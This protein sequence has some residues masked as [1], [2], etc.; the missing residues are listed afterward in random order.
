MS[1]DSIRGYVQIASGIGEATRARAVDI[2]SELV[3]VMSRANPTEMASYVTA[4]ADEAI[5]SAKANREMLIDLIRSEVSDLIDSSATVAKVTDLDGVKAALRQLADDLEGV[6]SQIGSESPARLVTNSAAAV[7]TAASSVRGKAKAA[8]RAAASDSRMTE[9]RPK[10]KRV[11]SRPRG[12]ALTAPATSSEATPT[13]KRVT[14][15]A[16]ETAPQPATVRKLTVPSAKK[17][18]PPPKQAAP[19]P[20]AKKAAPAAKEAVPAAKKVAPA[21]AAKK[22]APA[23]AA[24]K[25]APAVKK[26]APAPA[27]KKAAP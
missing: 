9:S 16:P 14:G 22:A 23:P 18:S 19:A 2:A 24:K 26:A 15:S 1:F 27:A 10:V 4:L 6:R 7:A 17:A 20:A 21:P 8:P 12:S 3:S 25:A 11:P 5:G 13:V